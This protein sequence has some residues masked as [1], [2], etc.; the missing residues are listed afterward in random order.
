MYSLQEPVPPAGQFFLVLELGKPPRVGP[1]LIEEMD[2]K[3]FGFPRGYVLV[4]MRRPLID[5]VD[6]K[7][8]GGRGYTIQVVKEQILSKAYN[9]VSLSKEP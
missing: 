2:P 7:P 8:T 9:F 4:E 5:Y 3:N 1:Q 6:R